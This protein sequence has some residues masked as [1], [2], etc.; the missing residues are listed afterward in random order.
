MEDKLTD[1]H[2]RYLLAIY[3]I[4]KSMPDVSS[5]SVAEKLGVSKPT[6][7]AMISGLSEKTLVVK[8]RYGKIYLTE[9]GLKLAQ[10]MSANI[11][12][13]VQQFSS[14][15]MALNQ[16]EMYQAAKAAAIALPN[17]D[18]RVLNEAV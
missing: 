4:S 13:L 9:Q 6:V 8:R 17:T 2:L 1:V 5:A 18:F 11:E 15:N 14:W 16:E 3:E 10:R 7:S 12:Y